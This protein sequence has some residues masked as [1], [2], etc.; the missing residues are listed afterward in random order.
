M[1]EQRVS[2]GSSAPFC[3]ERSNLCHYSLTRWSPACR[4]HIP[5]AA[6]AVPDLQPGSCCAGSLNAVSFPGQFVKR[7]L[8]PQ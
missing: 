6:W 2:S 5:E 7:N 4:E 1:H 8:W 3:G